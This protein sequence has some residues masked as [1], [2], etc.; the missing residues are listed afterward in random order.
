MLNKK[1]RLCIFDEK[2]CNSDS[3]VCFQYCSRRKK[4][5]KRKFKNI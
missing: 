2:S 3:V 1:I 5:G 4:Y